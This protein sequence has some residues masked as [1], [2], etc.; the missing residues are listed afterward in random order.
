MLCWERRV[1]PIGHYQSFIRA[2]FG[3]FPDRL[4]PGVETDIDLPNVNSNQTLTIDH[5]VTGPA[6]GY[7]ILHWTPTTDASDID[8][9]IINWLVVT[10]DEIRGVYQNPT[11][12]AIN[13][14]IIT[15][16]FVLATLNPDLVT[17][18]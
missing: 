8:D 6:L 9:M 1:R 17:V 13:P 12:G 11:G 4:L 3:R 7:H 10:D 2:V 5:A 15:F 14:G 18:V 16:Q